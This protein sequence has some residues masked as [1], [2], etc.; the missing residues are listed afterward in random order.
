ME[1]L[2]CGGESVKNEFTTKARKNNI[3]F[4][5]LK[6]RVF[7]IKLLREFKINIGFIA[8]LKWRLAISYEG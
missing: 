1:P 6:F 5:L 8:V 3:I 7:V 4:V 2:W